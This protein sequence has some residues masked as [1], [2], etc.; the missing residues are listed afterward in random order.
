MI[1]MLDITVPS[2]RKDA[3]AG[4]PPGMT[5]EDDLMRNLKLVA[6]GLGYKVYHNLYAIGSDRGYPDLHFVGYS[7]SLFLETKGPKWKISTEQEAWIADLQE[8]TP[9]TNGVVIASFAW[10]R[11]YGQVCD[12]LQERYQSW[13]VRPKERN[14]NGPQT[15]KANR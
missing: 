1:T 11:D 2:N 3:L 14:Y 15:D 12:L 8:L 6:K 5:T 9:L 4:A 10:P 7:L 13:L